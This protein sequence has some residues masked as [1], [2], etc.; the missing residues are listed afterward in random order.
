MQPRLD[1]L[2]QCSGMSSMISYDDIEMVIG[3][4]VA[5]LG[6]AVSKGPESE[7]EFRRRVFASHVRSLV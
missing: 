3:A 4:R 2:R 6:R 1:C 5:C 7:L